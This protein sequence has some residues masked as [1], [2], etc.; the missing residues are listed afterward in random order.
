MHRL[1]LD[2]KLNRMQRAIELLNN[3]IDNNYLFRMEEEYG[4]VYLGELQFEETENGKYAL[5]NEETE[6]Q[7]EHN[8][9]VF[10]KSH[11]LEAKE[12]KELWEIIQGKKY[13][14]YK[15][16]DGSDLRSWWD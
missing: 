1:S 5:V 7:K 6:E 9:M 16:W 2:K 14:G 13:K 12:W 4:K 15:N 3:K 11:E 10:K 8:R